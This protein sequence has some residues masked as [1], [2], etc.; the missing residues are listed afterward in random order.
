LRHLIFDNSPLSHFARAGRLDELESITKTYE[1]V[2]TQAV[3]DEISAGTSLH[4]ELA[5]VPECEWI[6]VVRVDSL[7]ELQVFAEYAA[8]LGSGE[9]DIGEASTLAWAEI[10][11]ATAVVDERAGT[12]QAREREVDVHGTLWLVVQ[13]FQSDA[14]SQGGCEQLVDALRDSEAWFPCDGSTFFEWAHR[15]GLV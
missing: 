14:I 15:E 2:V 11:A 9:R 4:A 3:L 13:A 7:R 1:R 5:A 10:H 8:R 12:R 6:H